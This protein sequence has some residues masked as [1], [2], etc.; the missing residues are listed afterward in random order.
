M[1]DSG[2][3]FSTNELDDFVKWCEP[4]RGHYTVQPLVENYR[5]A[6]KLIQARQLEARLEKLK[7][8]D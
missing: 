8:E 7:R 4:P 1:S 6:K 3:T 5:K 2:N